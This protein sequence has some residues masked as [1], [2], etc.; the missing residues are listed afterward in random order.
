MN[1]RK[2]RYRI[3]TLLSVLTL[4]TAGCSDDTTENTAQRDRLVTDLL[5]PGSTFYTSTTKELTIQGKGFAEGDALALADVATG[6]EIPL[7]LKAIDH[8][9]VTF[10]VPQEIPTGSYRLVVHRGQ[11]SQVLGI[12]KFRRSLDIEIPDKEGMNVKGVV[13]CGSLPVAGVVV[14]DGEVVTTTDDAGCYYLA[15][16]KHHG[17]VFMSVP[18][19]YEPQ[20]EN[21]VPLIWGP[22]TPGEEACE[23]VDFELVEAPGQDDFD[24]LVLADI[25]L[26]N[27]LGDIAQYKEL[28][29]PEVKNYIAASPRK[30]YIMNVGDMTFDLYW[31]SNKYNLGDYT[32]TLKDSAIPA[33]IYHVPGNHDNDE[34]A[35]DDYTAEQPYKDNLGPTYY[36][37]NIGKVHYVVL[38]DM[39]YHGRNK[40]DRIIAPEQLAWLYKDLRALDPEIRQLVVACHVPL[41]ANNGAWDDIWYNLK[42]KD[43]LFVLLQ[44]YDVTIMTGDWHTEGTT[45]V[46]DRI[47][48]YV[49]PAVTGNW[50]YRQGICCNGYPAAFTE[51]VF[52]GDRLESRSLID[53]ANGNSKQQ[54]RVYNKGVTSNT[55]IASSSALDPAGG[56]PSVLVFFWGVAPNWTFVCREN[57]E[58]TYGRGQLVQRY[59]PLARSLVEEG[60][61]PYERYTWLKQKP[62]R[63]YLYTPKDP[64]AEI[65]IV[66]TDHI[67]NRDFRVVT[68]IER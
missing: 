36:S 4:L 51:Y 57:G 14:S 55:G 39:L 24:L 8:A 67:R 35:N 62:V 31:N 52:R 16:K 15:S 3:A 30:V 22:V 60:I 9:Y 28:M 25:H 48:E 12:L 17:Y 27:R 40:Y 19:G 63:L 42:N 45:R 59:D 47:V 23:Q 7:T 66:G 54:Y 20:S 18:S 29:L 41:V 56:A 34:Y 37:F 6:A 50:W 11:E 58:L 61:I 53:W 26:A 46:S 65:E 2:F 43:E 64:G 1:N 49:H 13:F 32:N 10:A 21:S 38:D 33:L 5:V 68:R 44:D